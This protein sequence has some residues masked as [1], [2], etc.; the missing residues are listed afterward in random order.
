MQEDL[1]VIEQ[2]MEDLE[3]LKEAVGDPNSEFETNDVIRGIDEIILKI[4]D[5]KA[6]AMREPEGDSRNSILMDLEGKK[7]PLLEAKAAQQEIE[8]EILAL[9]QEEIRETTELIGKNPELQSSLNAKRF[10]LITNDERSIEFNLPI[11]KNDKSIQVLIIK[12]FLDLPFGSGDIFDEETKKS[13]IH[14][15]E[16]NRAKILSTMSSEDV[17]NVQVNIDVDF[18]TNPDFERQIGIV[19]TPTY[20]T[21]Y[22]SGLS[23]VATEVFAELEDIRGS[24][25]GTDDDPIKILS[26]REPGDAP[27]PDPW[28]DADFIYYTWV[29]SK[30]RRDVN[31]STPGSYDE[32]L[33]KTSEHALRIGVGKIFKYYDKMDTWEIKGSRSS[34]QAFA[35]LLFYQNK[36]PASVLEEDQKF[37]LTI[38]AQDLV[39]NLGVGR[40]PDPDGDPL[41]QTTSPPV[42]VLFGQSLKEG[43]A[44]NFAAIHKVHSPTRRPNSKFKFTVKIRKDLFNAIKYKP[45]SARAIGVGDAIRK[46]RATAERVKAFV[47]DLPGMMDEIGGEAAQRAQA[48]TDEIREAGQLAGKGISWATKNKEEALKKGAAGA[49][50]MAKKYSRA[51][52]L[53][54]FDN[55]SGMAGSLP[56]SKAQEKAF[57][58]ALAAMDHHRESMPVTTTFKAN[59][60]EEQIDKV[61]ELFSKY[62]LELMKWQLADGGRMRPYIEFKKEAENLRQVK[63]AIKRILSANGYSYQNGDTFEIQFEEV[64]LARAV[65]KKPP[66]FVEDRA[67]TV[68]VRISYKKKGKQ[69]RDL[70]QGTQAFGN[71]FPWNSPR[72]MNFLMN[73][74]SIYLDA[75]DDERTCLEDFSLFGSGPSEKMFEIIQ[76]YTT[77]YLVI[78][79]QSAKPMVDV[80]ANIEFE[81]PVKRF[82]DKLNEDFNLDGKNPKSSVFREDML[83]FETGKTYSLIDPIPKEDLCTLEQLYA[84]LLSKFDFEA[85]FCSYAACIPTI[86]WPISFK[87]DFDF[88]IPELPKLPKF[89]PMAILIPMIEAAILEMLIAFLCGIVRGILDLI[90]FPSCSDLLEFGAAAFES[91]FGESENTDKRLVMLKDAA[92]SLEEMD[93]PV[94]SYS[95]LADLFDALAMALT[96]PEI[97]SLLQG[98]ADVEIL[99]I[100]K[101]LIMNHSSTV[102]MFLTNESAIADFFLNLGKFIDPEL[103]NIMANSAEFILGDV[104]PDGSPSIRDELMRQDAT[105]E[106]ISKALVEAERRKSALKDLVDSNPLEGFF[107]TGL[108]SPYENKESHSMADLATKSVLENLEIAFKMDVAGWVPSLFESFSRQKKP[109]DPGFNVV[110]HA[111]YS[112]LV[113]ELRKVPRKAEKAGRISDGMNEQIRQINQEGMSDAEAA[114]AQAHFMDENGIMV[115]GLG[116]PSQAVGDIITSDN[117]IEMMFARTAGSEQSNGGGATVGFASGYAEAGDDLSEDIAVEFMR[118]SSGRSYWRV[119]VFG[120]EHAFQTKEGAMAF[121]SNEIA[122]LLQSTGKIPKPGP[123]HPDPENPGYYKCVQMVAAPQGGAL[124]SPIDREHLVHKLNSIVTAQ[125]LVGRRSDFLTQGAILEQEIRQEIKAMDEADENASPQFFDL[126][127]AGDRQFFTEIVNFPLRNLMDDTKPLPW[128]EYVL[129]NPDDII[130]FGLKS[131]APWDFSNPLNSNTSSPEVTRREPYR[132]EL[133]IKLPNSATSVMDTLD[134]RYEPGDSVV[135]QEVPIRGDELCDRYN[136]LRPSRLMY[137]AWK[138][139]SFTDEVPDDIA[140]KRRM[141]MDFQEGNS[142]DYRL[143]RP[144]AFANMF[145]ESWEAMLV[146]I[147][148]DGQPAMINDQV[149]TYR[150]ELWQK[151]EGTPAE[152]LAD[153]QEFVPRGAYDSMARHFIEKLS[154]SVSDSPFFDMDAIQDFGKFISSEFLYQGEGDDGCYVKNDGVIDFQ[155]IRKDIMEKYIRSLKD[156]ENDPTKRDFNKSGPLEKSMVSQ[157]VLFYMKTY[158]I[159]FLLKGMFVFSVFGVKGLAKSEMIKQYVYDYFNATFEGVLS[160]ITAEEASADPAESFLQEIYKVANNTDLKEAVK[161]IVAEIIES[162][163]LVEKAEKLYNPLYNSYKEFCFNEMVG[164]YPKSVIDLKTIAPSL[165]DIVGKEEVPVRRGLIPLHKSYN[166]QNPFGGT[167]I[168]NIRDLEYGKFYVETYWRFSEGFVSRNIDGALTE[169]LGDRLMDIPGAFENLY[170]EFLNTRTTDTYRGVFSEDELL[171]FLKFVTSLKITLSVPIRELADQITNDLTTTGN[172]KSGMR[173]VFV[174]GLMTGTNV[175][176]YKWEQSETGV[177][178]SKPPPAKVEQTPSEIARQM[179]LGI[180]SVRPDQ[181]IGGIP[182][183]ELRLNPEGNEARGIQLPPPEYSSLTGQATAN[184]PID[185]EKLLGRRNALGSEG[186]WYGKRH[187]HLIGDIEEEMHIQNISD[188]E[189]MEQL[190]RAGAAEGEALEELLHIVELEAERNIEREEHNKRARYENPRIRRRN[191]AITELRR[192]GG[193]NVYHFRNFMTARTRSFIGDTTPSM[194]SGK[195]FSFTV[196]FNNFDI[197]NREKVKTICKRWLVEA[198]AD[199]HEQGSLAKIATT[200]F[201]TSYIYGTPAIELFGM[202]VDQQHPSGDGFVERPQDHGVFTTKPLNIMFPT[203]ITTLELDFCPTELLESEYIRGSSDDQS[204][205]LRMVRAKDEDLIQQMFGLGPADE[206]GKRNL[207]SEPSFD[208]RYL[209]DFIFPL[210]RYASVFTLHNQA[211]FD[212]SAP[213]ATAFEPTRG[214]T[215]RLVLTLKNPDLMG[216]SDQAPMGGGS[217]YNSLTSDA[218]SNGFGDFAMGQMGDLGKM[219]EKLV[220]QFVPNLIRG[221]AGG[222]DPAYKDLKKKFDA[223]PAF[224]Q[225]GLTWG[226]LS[227]GS[228]N[229][230]SPT[231]PMQD[232]F[233]KHGS[234]NTYAPMNLQGPLDLTIASGLIATGL[235]MGPAGIGTVVKGV[236]DT[237]TIVARLDASIRQDNPDRYG[238][239]LTPFGMLALGMGEHT[240]ERHSDRVKKGRSRVFKVC[241]GEDVSPST[242]ADE[243]SEI[244]E[245]QNRINGLLG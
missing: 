67:G 30:T 141:A 77:P 85:L 201:D 45:G 236:N 166:P 63:S 205:S 108:P 81:A 177:D 221:L 10:I 240:G 65:T 14:W 158:V 233:V 35:P 15:Q 132:L 109:G 121:V 16:M 228:N 213:A 66:T 194:A 62:S 197:V 229:P 51:A 209:F 231:D 199:Q 59:E 106:E 91:A 61:A 232:G 80:G 222:M 163:D 127:I 183:D 145:M 189:A 215:R 118:H 212:L 237:L 93:I 188:V 29:S 155:K 123:A 104:C 94:D 243:A 196:D 138:G 95:D 200:G 167:D 64:L 219:L 33:R 195:P 70:L 171:D 159:E 101:Q 143:L 119:H 3:E 34:H 185:E 244:E 202:P 180:I 134:L 107:D 157:M 46:A 126:S 160:S 140:H 55:I 150:N 162:D 76:N 28:K 173:L 122:S 78:L 75:L 234:I 50:N 38:Q 102:S 115:F 26:E 37:T 176:R 4:D 156:P 36:L 8:A 153:G 181:Q 182:M 7:E 90:K 6:K 83:R 116:D 105:P 226:S 207:I 191:R 142:D 112:Y 58:A 110:E 32:F 84:E 172:I 111:E 203:P 9:E 1:L 71:M 242:D 198:L 27:S 217:L 60:F 120:S 147:Y 235:A 103:C 74:E 86:P 12:R 139:Q 135:Y 227:H 79:K 210:D 98:E 52:E 128:M 39:K 22:Q 220:T 44:A 92:A 21:M 124:A 99:S 206:N 87:W 72:T 175:D 88:K 57:Q 161:A 31:A 148:P 193:G 100:A 42:D 174:P 224:T 18:F 216:L 20:L 48:A 13:L 89:D 165:N 53:A 41:A 82:F 47:S 204:P 211:M 43:A 137:D 245:R 170:E 214:T 187:D 239:F 49:W 96:P 131:G 68:P 186:F 169:I 24:I 114:Q 225:R 69:S 164:G 238:R 218:T 117:F 25:R 168:E 241:E 54:K 190:I 19:D 17:G 154:N 11:K 125:R 179:A 151:F 113:E 152:D 178:G 56:F 223:D 192:D 23:A 146:D 133:G 129:Q 144:A 230:Y 149:T 208:I 73:L 184:N 2:M 97:C 130:N 5:L 40:V 136:I